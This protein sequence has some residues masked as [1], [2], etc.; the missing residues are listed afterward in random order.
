MGHARWERTKLTKTVRAATLV[1]ERLVGGSAHT[2]GLVV[3]DGRVGR[4]SR[5]LHLRSVTLLG[6]NGSAFSLS[7]NG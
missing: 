4:V 3:L 7:T 5:L 1:G 6:N 2:F